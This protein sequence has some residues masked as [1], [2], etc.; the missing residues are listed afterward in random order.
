MFL[1]KSLIAPLNTDDDIPADTEGIGEGDEGEDAGN[2]AFRSPKEEL[3]RIAKSALN[4]PRKE[5]DTCTPEQKRIEQA[6]KKDQMDELAVQTMLNCETPREQMEDIWNS[7]W[8]DPR[9]DQSLKKTC[10]AL[11]AGVMNETLFGSKKDQDK[12]IKQA[13]ALRNR[14]EW[15]LDKRHTYRRMILTDDA[16]SWLRPVED[17][18]AHYQP[19]WCPQEFFDDCPPT[20]LVIIIGYRTATVPGQ[21]RVTSLTLNQPRNAANS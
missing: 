15:T 9:E 7:V 13:Y 3:E 21:S 8:T 12:F 20:P 4:L 6:M 5:Q 17:M 10:I 19:P 11:R 2:V 18:V 14:G 1:L 16:S